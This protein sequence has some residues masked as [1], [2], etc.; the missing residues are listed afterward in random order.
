MVELIVMFV[1]QLVA[2]LTAIFTNRK[3]KAA[4][5]AAAN[6]AWEDWFK[7]NAAAEEEAGKDIVDEY[8]R[9]LSEAVA[10]SERN[11]ILI[12]VTVIILV[13]AMI[14]ILKLIINKSKNER[15][16]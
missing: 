12:G 16:S 15:G 8:R 3:K 11:A 10:E 13:V 7:D 14:F 1:S 4:E 5:W 2:S 9:Q 6:A